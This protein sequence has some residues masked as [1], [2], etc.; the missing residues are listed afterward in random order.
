MQMLLNPFEEQFHVPAF[1][2]EFCYGQSIVSE[3]IGQET[4]DVAGGEVFIG[5]HSQVF[6]IALSGLVGSESDDLISDNTCT[7]VERIRRDNIVLHIVL[8]PGNEECSVPVYSVEET[9]EVNISLIHNIDCTHLY[10]EFIQHPDI[11]YGSIC[12]IDECRDI[13]TKIEKR[14]HLHTSLC[15]AELCP[16]TELQTKTDCTAVEGIDRI[17]KIQPEGRVISIK[18]PHFID[19]SLPEVPI[20]APVAE[21]VCLSQS[22]TGNCITDTAHIQLVGDCRKTCFDI[23]ETVLV[24]VLSHTHYQEL[25]VAGEV[26]DTIVPVVAG[27]AIVELAS[28]NEGHNLGKYCASLVHRGNDSGLSRKAIDSNRVHRKN[29]ISS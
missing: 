27:N 3:M 15:L 2:V 10:A 21:F 18:R 19:E 16:R 6:G 29:V 23:P 4:I 20:Y 9:E 1:A 25:V 12:E 22:V 11:M 17:V 7:F 8:C 28:W 13:T 24:R 14:M 26:P 5:D